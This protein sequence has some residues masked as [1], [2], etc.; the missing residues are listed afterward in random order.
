MD[1]L[2]SEIDL[3]RYENVVIVTPVWVFRM[4]APVRQFIID[5]K[6]SLKDK[7]VS[8]IFN[9]FNPWLPKGAIKEVDNYIAVKEVKSYTTMLGHTFGL[10]G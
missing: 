9:H 5:N 10:K 6:D 7:S 2:P 8:I 3:A 1:L 4:C